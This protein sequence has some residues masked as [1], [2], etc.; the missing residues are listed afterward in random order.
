MARI[1]QSSPA[2]PAAKVKRPNAPSSMTFSRRIGS[3]VPRA[4]VV[5]AIAITTGDEAS[6][7]T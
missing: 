4:V 6:C 3:S 5:T 1:G 2:A 7:K